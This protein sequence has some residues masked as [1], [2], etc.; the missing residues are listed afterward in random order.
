M[1]DLVFT[2]DVPPTFCFSC[3]CPRPLASFSPLCI[4]EGGWKLVSVALGTGLR[5]TVAGCLCLLSLSLLLDSFWGDRLLDLLTG[6]IPACGL[7]LAVVGCLPLLCAPLR[8]SRGAGFVQPLYNTVKPF[9]DWSG[10]SGRPFRALSKHS[11]ARSGKHG[12]NVNSDQELLYYKQNCGI[13][14]LLSI[15]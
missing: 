13:M 10:L 7:A 9:S 11:T 5:L 2:A 15:E 6:E 1:P 3:C 12:V 8:K 14:N 4:L